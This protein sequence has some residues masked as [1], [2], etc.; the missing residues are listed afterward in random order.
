MREE[1]RRRG[2][3]HWLKWVARFGYAARGLVYVATGLFALAAALTRGSGAVGTEGALARLAQ[4]PFGAAWLW[5]AGAGLLAFAVWRFVQAGFD[6]DQGGVGRGRALHRL[7]RAISGAVHAALGWSAFQALDGLED[8]AEEADARA[9]AA[10]ILALPFGD[11]LLWGAAAALAVAAG[12]N[13][14]KAWKHDFAE[15]LGASRT[16]RRWAP[17]LG[18]AGYAARGL[19][20]ALVALFLARA[21]LSQDAGAA[22]SVG[23][24]MQALETQ[25]FGSAL[26]AAV[27]AGFLAFG[28]YAFVQAAWRRIRVPR[29]LR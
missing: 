21:A 27:A 4:G 23:G 9:Q 6:P 14:W 5:I 10:Q 26:L 7:N 28:A 24:A 22:R 15:D 11:L 18:R 3:D 13:L 20:F 12:G 29:A 8:L 16:A 1:A 25:P 17:W 2:L 19:V